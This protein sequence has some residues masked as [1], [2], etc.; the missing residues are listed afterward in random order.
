MLDEKGVQDKRSRAGGLVAR[1]GGLVARV[2]VRASKDKRSRAGGL[3]A[4]VFVQT[5]GGR[6]GASAEA[7]R[8]IITAKALR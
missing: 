4:R 5:E 1:A 2:F 8:K 3:V 6:M 7:T